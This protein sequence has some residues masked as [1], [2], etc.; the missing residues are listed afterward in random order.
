[1][2]HFPVPCLEIPALSAASSSAVHFC[3]GAPIRSRALR[4]RPGLLLL[5]SALD[6]NHNAW[7]YLPNKSGAGGGSRRRGES[8]RPVS[9]G[10]KSNQSLDRRLER[11]YD[12]DRPRARDG[13]RGGVG[14]GGD[15]CGGRSGRA[16]SSRAGDQERR[17]KGGEE[18]SRRRWTGI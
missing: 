18:K 14:A 11:P 5:T 17:G 9:S 1:V 4:R 10:L 13:Q 2:R 15:G 6:H 12:R 3:F 8:W 16:E 7:Y